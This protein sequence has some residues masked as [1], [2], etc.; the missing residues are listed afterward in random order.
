MADAKIRPEDFPAQADKQ[1]ATNKAVREG[2]EGAQAR[3]INKEKAEK[4]KDA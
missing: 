1:A 2:T 4:S 3:E